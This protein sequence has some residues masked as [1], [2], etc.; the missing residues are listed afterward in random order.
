[1]DSLKSYVNSFF[2]DLGLDA[3]KNGGHF[4]KQYISK[5]IEEFL[6]DEIKREAYDIFSMFLDIYRANISGERSF[7][8]LLDVLRSYEENAAVLNEKQRDH[9]IH[10]MNVFLLGLSIY[11]NNRS[12]RDTFTKWL[13]KSS[14]TV[15]FSTAQEEFFFRWGIASLF[16]DAGYP[17]EIINNQFKRFVAFVSGEDE[18]GKVLAKPY[19]SYF[20]FGKIN[21]INGLDFNKFILP[22][23]LQTAFEEK[24]IDI[25]SITE[26]LA[27]NLS[28]SLG[29]PLEETKGVLNGFLATMQKYQFVDHG[30]Y[31]AIIVVKW[32]GELMMK[33]PEPS[34]LLFSHILDSAS[35]IFLH[36]AYRNVFTKEPFSLPPLKPE[37]HPIGFLLTLCDESQEW[38]REAYGI[39]SREAV[40]IDSSKVSIDDREFKL[41][42]VTKEGVLEDNFVED[43]KAMLGSLLNYK[44][45][46]ENGIS[47]SATTLSE[48]YINR[49]VSSADELTPRLLIEHIESIAMKIHENYNKKQL[50]DNPDKPL[51]YP[52]WIS[53]PDTLKYSNI[54]QAKDIAYRLRDIG[55][56]IAESSDDV[57]VFSFSDNEIE[58]LAEK[59]HESWMDERLKNGWVYG[60]NKNVKL[61]QSPYIVPYS[62]LTEEIKDYDRDAVKNILPLLKEVGLKVYRVK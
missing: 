45:I 22:G 55:C 27:F 29:T 51:A 35:G 39:K 20:D 42:Y 41:H 10:S 19:L 17:V 56:Y 36:N 12:Y 47:I 7:I 59:E 58:F 9:Y 18:K 61:K 52:T 53:L 38:N 54:R 48:Q 60:A 50:A 57:E 14:N 43:K 28:G 6:D 13:Q 26:Y 32:F 15:H 8:D 5:E 4:Y 2:Q 30:F 24:T 31:S 44:S 33:S 11:A 3:D 40:F 34:D 37:K 1:M 21:S 25:N 16:H 62:E 46:F 23:C 49:I